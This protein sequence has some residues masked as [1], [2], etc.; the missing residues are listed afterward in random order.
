[1][2]HDDLNYNIILTLVRCGAGN[3]DNTPGY[4]D[5]RPGSKAIM[6]HILADP[7]SIIHPL[8]FVHDQRME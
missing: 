7:T 1:M 8:S 6:E 4:F 5:T 2:Q 3:E